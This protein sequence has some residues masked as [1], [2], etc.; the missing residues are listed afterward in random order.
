MPSSAAILAAWRVWLIVAGTPAPR[1]NPA[2]LTAAESPVPAPSTTSRNALGSSGRDNGHS[3][4]PAPPHRIK[5]WIRLGI[6][7]SL[8]ALSHWL[9]PT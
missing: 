4:E 2:L 3:R 5:G 9:R 6:R 8:G 1:T 7:L